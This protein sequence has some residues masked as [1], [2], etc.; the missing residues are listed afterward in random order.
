[1]EIKKCSLEHC[2]TEI[3][4]E[5]LKEVKKENIFKDDEDPK[6]RKKTITNRKER[7]LEKR[8]HLVFLERNKRG[9]R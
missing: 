9:T 5:F 6:E 8:I 1:M 3:E 7:L 2:L 4:K